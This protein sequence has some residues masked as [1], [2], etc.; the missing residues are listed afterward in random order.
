MIQKR[1]IRHGTYMGCRGGCRRA[2]KG[3]LSK[4]DLILL[5]L[6]FFGLF[7][8]AS[9]TWEVVDRLYGCYCVDYWPLLVFPYVPSPLQIVGA[10]IVG[11]GACGAFLLLE[12]SRYSPNVIALVG[13]VSVLATN[14]LQGPY[15]GFR[16]PL[17]MGGKQYYHDALQI[18]KA[19]EFISTF[20]AIRP[21]LT[22]HA[23]THPPGAVLFFYGLDWFLAGPE[24]IAA[25]MGILSV[26]ILTVFMYGMLRASVDHE[27]AGFTTVLFIVFP[28]TQIYAVASLDILIGALFLAATYFF[29][30]QPGWI[31]RIGSALSLLMASFLNFAFLFLL[32]LLSI[33]EWIRRRS[34][35]RIVLLCGVLISVYGA[36]WA[37]SGFNYA[38]AF[39]TAFIE[40]RPGDEAFYYGP[41][42]YV[43]TRLQNVA[44]LLFFLGPFLAYLGWKGFR[45]A[46]LWG[47]PLALLGILGVGAILAVYALG[48]YKDG[49][50]SRNCF[51]VYPFLFFFVG[52]SLRGRTLSSRARSVLFALVFGQT[53]LMQIVGNYIY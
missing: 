1:D 22:I 37:T 36:L 26:L 35:T 43:P 3:F 38:E 11:F 47:E 53:V 51:Y 40:E 46:D 14:L 9:V 45:E 31:G 19:W 28:A 21:T 10:L 44:D 42:W 18:Q 39:I 20:E 49:T 2:M 29:V 50:T 8:L 6:V 41:S 13:M 5:P 25:V 32:L 23:R 30:R 33:Y 48:L 7:A 12:R 4:R 17:T 34:L 27:T 24:V 16:I 52:L 15:L